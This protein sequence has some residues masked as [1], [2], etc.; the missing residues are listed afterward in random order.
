MTTEEHVEEM[1]HIAYK[2]GVLDEFHER[3]RTQHKI[4]NDSLPEVIF[5]TFEN[6]KKEGLIIESD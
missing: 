3:V 5:K 1:F 4:N 6:F 2:C